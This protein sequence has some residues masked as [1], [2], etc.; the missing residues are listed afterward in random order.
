MTEAG[1]SS[2]A[3]GRVVLEEWKARLHEVMYQKQ[4]GGQPTEDDQSH[5]VIAGFI[6]ETVLPAFWDIKT[7]LEEHGR[8]IEVQRSPLQATLIVYKDD[9]EEFSYCV[10]GRA[11]HAMTSAF[12]QITPDEA[13]TS[14]KVEVLLYTGKQVELNLKDLTRERILEDF[15]KGYDKW[16]GW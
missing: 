1:K 10:R 16:A 15:L 2:E 14:Y 13:P 5:R 4:V 11:Y 6:D 12:P 8:S 9:E 7:A 3:L